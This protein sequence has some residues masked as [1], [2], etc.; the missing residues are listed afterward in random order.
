MHKLPLSVL[1]VVHTSEGEFLLLERAQRP[2]F[3]QSVTGSLDAPDEPLQRAAAREVLEETSIAAPAAALE[4]LDVVNTFEIYSQWR[5][6]YAPGVTH[7]TE[8]VYCL[9][10]PARV[11][12]RIAPREHRAFRW[13]PWQEAAE[14]CFSWSNR[15]AIR[16]LAERGG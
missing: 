6:R 2:G 14:R 1:V 10:L 3:W 4:P 5:D 13:S 16:L 15:D 8:H 7:N 9:R 11:P 12:V